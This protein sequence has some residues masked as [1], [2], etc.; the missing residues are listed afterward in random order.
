MSP[1]A[2]NYKD[3]DNSPKTLIYKEKSFVS[4]ILEF[5]LFNGI[6]TFMGY[7]MTDITKE[8]LE[9]EHAYYDITVQDVSNNST[10]ISTAIIWFT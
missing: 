2:N 6:S 10:N 5:F 3:E 1:A 9:F 7:L 4:D 8:W